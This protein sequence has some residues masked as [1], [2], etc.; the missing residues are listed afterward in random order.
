MPRTATAA[1]LAID[2]TAYQF[3]HTRTPRGRGGWIFAPKG[4][5]DVPEAWKTSPSMT[6]GDAV[7]WLRAQGATGTW[8]AMP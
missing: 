7:K 3:S 6:Y 4:G 5:E 8:V 2:T 1:K